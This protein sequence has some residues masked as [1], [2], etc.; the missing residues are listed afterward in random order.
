LTLVPELGEIE[1]IFWADFEVLIEQPLE[2]YAI[3][4]SLSGS[5]LV[6]L[7]PSWLVDGETVWGLTGLILASLLELCFDRKIEWYYRAQA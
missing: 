3:N 7:T 6:L 4:Y 2:E 5:N 1:R